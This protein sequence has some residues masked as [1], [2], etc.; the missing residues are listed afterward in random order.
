MLFDDADLKDERMGSKHG[1]PYFVHAQ[2]I[3]HRGHIS[4][5]D[6]AYPISTVNLFQA[7]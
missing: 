4:A 2:L 7:S 6:Y 1:R 3:R 5:D